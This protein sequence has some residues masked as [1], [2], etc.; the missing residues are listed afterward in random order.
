MVISLHTPANGVID[1]QV[2]ANCRVRD[3]PGLI[4]VAAEG[5]PIPETVWG[6]EGNWRLLVAE[7]GGEFQLQEAGLNYVC[8]PAQRIQW[9]DI[10][11]PK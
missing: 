3:I 7:H 2:P 10:D 6:V 4:F 9:V 8:Q 11:Q 5:A 1:V